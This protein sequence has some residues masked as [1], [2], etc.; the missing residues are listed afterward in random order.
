MDEKQIYKKIKD[1]SDR[2]VSGSA[3]CTRAD[4]AYELKDLGF[5]KDSAAVGEWVW[6]AY[7]YY[8]RYE[9]IRKAFVNNEKKKSLV[10]EYSI[11]SSV[12]EGNAEEVSSILDADI[13]GSDHALALLN[14][15]VSKSM[16]E[17]SVSGAGGIVGHITGTKAVSDIRAMA[18]AVFQNYSEMVSAYEEAKSQVKSTIADFVAVRTYVNDIYRKY[19]LALVDIFGDSVKAVSP[20]LFDFDTIQWLDVQGMLQN[21]QLEYEQVM[22]RCG[23]L[24]SV[25]SENFSSTVKNAAYSYRA[26][27]SKQAGLVLAGMGMI[28]HYLDAHERASEL[29]GQLLTLK[30][31]VR[32]DATLI[33]GDMGRLLLIYKGMNDFHIPRAEAF[34]R[35]SRS[36]IESDINEMIEAVYSTPGLENLREERESLLAEYSET[37]RA[38]ADSQANISYYTSHIAECEALIKSM[39]RQY[40]DAKRSKPSKPFFL[41]N[42]FTFG[43]SSKKYNREIAEWYKLCQPVISQYEGL[44]VDIDLDKKD[45]SVHRKACDEGMHRMDE[46]KV[47]LKESGQKMKK[48]ISVDAQSKLK[49]VGHLDTL[50]KLLRTARE[51]ASTRLDEKLLRTVSIPDYRN[52]QLP[53]EISENIHL[54]AQVVREGLVMEHLQPA[55]GTEGQADGNASRRNID[56]YAN[57]FVDAQ[58]AVMQKTVGLFEALAELE[59][60]K[61]ESRIIGSKYDMEL[62]K[63]QSE[64]RREMSKIDE[65]SAVLREVLKKLNTS[66]DASQLRDALAALSDKQ[67]NLTDKDWNDFF[68]GNKT[69]EL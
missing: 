47:R 12:G 52:E 24:I 29:K 38:V 39:S 28:M 16:Q 9:N 21:V 14:T 18:S 60:K 65:K 48:A 33:K 7:T 17:V 37:E 13:S 57:R 51:I 69:I 49:I 61:A 1:L 56:E 10:D 20:E 31:N 67:E 66:T 42:I 45:L 4:L 35:Y 27:G 41:M 63:M 3:L 46:I 6:K 54:L 62:K 44:Q 23:E 32:H 19:S 2:I 64:F 30:N 15:A 59:K 34:Y 8:D 50:I 11:Y 22:G 40:E 25:I 58:N 36:V 43:A 68:N 5:D 53:Q 26:A 55:A